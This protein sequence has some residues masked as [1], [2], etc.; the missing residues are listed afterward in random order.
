MKIIFLDI[1]GV[2]NNIAWLIRKGRKKAPWPVGD[3]APLNVLQLNRITDITGAGIV[4]TS[5][6]RKGFTDPQ[7]EIFFGRVGITGALVGKTTDLPDASFPDGVEY[8]WPRGCEIDHF[9]LALKGVVTTYVILDD[10]SDMLLQQADN[11]VQTDEEFGV[12]L[13]DADKAIEILERKQ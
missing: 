12:T 5:A 9:L 11:F 2:L 8:N 3:V 10:E 6:W 1:D 13:K 7:L 4:I